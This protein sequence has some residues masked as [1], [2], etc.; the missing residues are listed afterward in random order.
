MSLHIPPPSPLLRLTRPLASTLGLSTL[1][2][3][4]HEALLSTLLYSS[5]FLLSPRLSTYLAPRTYPRL[6]RPQRVSW[7][8]HV[9]SFVQSVVVCGMAVYTIWVDPTREGGGGGWR[10]RLWGYSGMAGTV[11]GMAMGYFVW[12]CAVSAMYMGTLGGSSL[13]HAVA[14]LVVTL[15][16]FRPFANYY[17]L[18]FILYELSTPFLNIHWF[19]DKLSLTGSRAQLYNGIALLVSFGGA[20]LV[21]GTYQSALIYHDVWMAWG[22]RGTPLGEGCGRY[23]DPG[24]GKVVGEGFGVPVECQE[25]PA[26]LAVLYLGSNTI[27][28]LLNFW[29]FGKMITAVRKRFVKKEGKGDGEK[30][31]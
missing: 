16:G 7:D 12:D 31:E 11:Q 3:H 27:L 24:V 14:A 13:V 17:G 22:A 18:N 8:T 20:R 15:I 28:S 10:G 29:W 25:L 23:L 1:P 4:L 30:K 5:L 19:L 2:H 6:T 9:V 21:W 26:W